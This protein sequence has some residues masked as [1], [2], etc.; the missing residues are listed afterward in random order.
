MFRQPPPGPQPVWKRPVYLMA[1]AILGGL[2]GFLL[3]LILGGLNLE[4]ALISS[5]RLVLVFYAIDIIG[6]I[7]GFFV[8]RLWWRLVYIE[9]RWGATPNV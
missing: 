4:F 2:L 5:P 8:G 9:R 3:T 7:S 6:L 1:S